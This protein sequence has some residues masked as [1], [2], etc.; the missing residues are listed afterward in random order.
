M[1]ATAH[2]SSLAIELD[3]FVKQ[4]ILLSRNMFSLAL[5]GK[6]AYRFGIGRHDSVTRNCRSIRVPFQGLTHR[7]R[8]L[9]INA[10][11]NL[12]IGGDLA[13]RYEAC[14]SKDFLL[15]GSD[16]NVTVLFG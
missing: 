16:H 15:K 1:E 12:L 7:L 13:G 6:A 2:H 4:Q 3:P 10:T 9:A 5:S 11:S 8:T 14:G